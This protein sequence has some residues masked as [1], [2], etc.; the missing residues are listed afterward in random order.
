MVPTIGSWT[1]GSGI[2]AMESVDAM[3]E[4]PRNRVFAVRRDEDEESLVSKR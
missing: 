1:R 3:Y 2:R 4:E